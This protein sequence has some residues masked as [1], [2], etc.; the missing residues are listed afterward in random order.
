MTQ[1]LI[2]GQSI[3][4]GYLTPSLNA[5]WWHGEELVKVWNNAG[6]REDNSF[7]GSAYVNPTEGA[8]PFPPAGRKPPA[9]DVLRGLAWLRE[10][11]AVR[12]VIVTRD[13][14]K[15]SRW[16]ANGVAQPLLVRTINV[17]D[18]S[19]NHVASDW[20]DGQGSA[21]KGDLSTFFDEKIAMYELLKTA[22]VVND[23]TFKVFCE[24]AD[25]CADV[26][27]ELA[28]VVAAIPNAKLAKTGKVPTS[29]GR[30]PTAGGSALWASA[31]MQ[32]Y[33]E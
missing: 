22:G 6:N 14:A 16:V 32:T 20:I 11:N 17:W 33:M 28:R 19:G 30:H 25:D 27:V 31:I 1:A 18:A 21:N 10:N 7:L 3:P 9:L 26:N 5:P 8:A 29:D 2:T 13:G 15:S 24:Q 4:W 12:G 23:S